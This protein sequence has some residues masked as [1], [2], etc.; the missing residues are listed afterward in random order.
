MPCRV[1]GRPVTLPSGSRSAPSTRKYTTLT[2][3]QSTTYKNARSLDS[4]ESTT[5]ARDAATA[6]SRFK[7]P[8]AAT[9]YPES[10]P[11]AVLETK[12]NFPV[13]SAGYR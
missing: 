3:A 12:A 2:N 4:A 9:W 7:V 13:P 11:L 10:V 8:F 1:I 5:S 6:L